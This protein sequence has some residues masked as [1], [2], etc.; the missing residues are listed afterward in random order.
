MWRALVTERG[1]LVTPQGFPGVSLMGRP[2]LPDAR[3]FARLLL[4][5]AFLRE[6][7]GWGSVLQ[8][9]PARGLLGAHSTRPSCI[10]LAPGRAHSAPWARLRVC[11]GLARRPARLYL[12]AG[13]LAEW[14]PRSAT[15][16]GLSDEVVRLGGQPLPSP[17]L[18]VQETGPSRGREPCFLHSL[19]MTSAT[20]WDR[21]LSVDCPAR[22]SQRR[23]TAS[24]FLDSLTFFG[25]CCR[26]R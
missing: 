16:G 4:Q 20:P 18:L 24:Q 8:G 2:V 14:H 25:G 23:G 19:L 3:D 6:V 5:S 13:A 22:L 9:E 10:Q 17:L 11:R 26:K 21:W 15:P 1:G 7:P 12:P